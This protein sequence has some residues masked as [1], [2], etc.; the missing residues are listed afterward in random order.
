[1]I[2]QTKYDYAAKYLP[3]NSLNKFYISY[4]PNKCWPWLGQIKK[5]DRCGYGCYNASHIFGFNQKLYAH[6]LIYTIL[7]GTIDSS[8]E[9]DHLCRNRTCVNPKHLEPVPGIING[10]RGEGIGVIND[11]KTHCPQG[12]EYN[13]ENTILEKTGISGNLARRCKI[14]RYRINKEWRERNR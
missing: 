3:K 11:N 14:C 13:K 10:K 9:L 6:R 1:M 4:D 5:G 8:L 12:H 2:D 7:I